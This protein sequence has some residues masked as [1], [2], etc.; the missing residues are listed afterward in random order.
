MLAWLSPSSRPV[1]TA[2]SLISKSNPDCLVLD[3]APSKGTEVKALTAKASLDNMKT[4]LAG[5]TA[6]NNRYYKSSTGQA[7]SVWIRDTLQNVSPIVAC[8]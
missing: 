1:R 4:I 7:A 3:P 6:F 8:R 2:F 5:L